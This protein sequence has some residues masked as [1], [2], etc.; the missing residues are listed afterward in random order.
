MIVEIQNEITAKDL[1]NITIAV[2][3]KRISSRLVVAFGILGLILMVAGVVSMFDKKPLS[4]L[5]LFM[6]V[7]NG[8]MP[9][10]LMYYARNQYNTNKLYQQPLTFTFAEDKI[11][12]KGEHTEGA[13][14]WELINKCDKLKHFL[15]LYFSA[16]QVGFIKTD[17]LKPEQIAFIQS[18][19][20]Q[21]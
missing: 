16:R 8:I 19:I 18:K 13:Y 21:P 11:S 17:T 9:F 2:F 1:T 10:Y 14:D 5:V 15:V 7:L 12:Y 3:Y 20:K 4:Y 6:I